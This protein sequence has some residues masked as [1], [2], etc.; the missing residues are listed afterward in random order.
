MAT[1]QALEAKE[2]GERQTRPLLAKAE[3]TLLLWTT[4]PST[5]RSRRPPPRYSAPRTRTAS[6]PSRRT[7]WTPTPA[8]SA[9]SGA[10][11]GTPRGCESSL[12]APSHLLPGLFHPRPAWRLPELA[13]EPHHVLHEVGLGRHRAGPLLHHLPQDGVVRDLVLY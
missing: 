1:L 6:L 3:R 2:L 11:S 9:C 12:Q 5:T 4:R 7:S 8:Y 10:S 13:L